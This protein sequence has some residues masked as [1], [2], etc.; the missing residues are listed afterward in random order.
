MTSCSRSAALA[1]SCLVL[2]ACDAGQDAESSSGLSVGTSVQ[3][4]DVGDD[5]RSYRVHRPTSPEAEPALVL[6]LH[7]GGGS[8]RQA[9]ESY[10]WT[11]LADREGFLVVHPQGLHHTWN[12]GGGCCG[13]AAE[14]AV[15]D[16]AFLTAVVDDVARRTTVDMGR[17]FVTGMSNGAMMSYTLACSTDVFAAIAPVAGTML[18]D[19]TDPAPVS[20][21]HL[22]GTA[23]T[24]VRMDGEPGEGPAM[25]DGRPVEDVVAFWRAVD[26]CLAPTDVTAG[27]V[28]RSVSGC[29]DGRSVE[30]VTVDGAGHQWPG[31]SVVRAAAD[32]PYPDLDA[33]ENIWRFFEAHPAA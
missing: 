7:G 6:V 30:F 23:D 4:L 28:H 9:E 2:A 31:S 32:P 8:A 16:V 11:A 21:F 20:V 15:D 24:S 25:V 1:V 22:H 33:T 10:G 17:V 3:R 13:R 5:E 27:P 26:G 14:Q 18:A 29:S 12:T 19:C